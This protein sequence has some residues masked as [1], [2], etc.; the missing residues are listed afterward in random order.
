MK[1]LY[2]GCRFNDVICQAGMAFRVWR[3]RLVR[4]ALTMNVG[5]GPGFEL[6]IFQEVKSGKDDPGQHQQDGQRLSRHWRGVSD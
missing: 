2:A 5:T 6:E 4:S 1:S 3:E